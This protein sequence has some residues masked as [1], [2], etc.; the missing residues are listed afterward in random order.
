M[1][2]SDHD[3]LAVDLVLDVPIFASAY[4]RFNLE[5]LHEKEFKDLFYRAWEGW[6][7]LRGMANSPI[8]WWEGIKGKFRR[9]AQGYCSR[10]K[11]RREREVLG[12]QGQLEGLYR[13]YNRGEGFDR[14]EAVRLKGQLREK[15]ESRA[16]EFLFRAQGDELEKGEWCSAYF[17]GKVREARRKKVIRGLRGDDGSV[18]TD[19][20]GMG[21]VAA[22]FYRSLFEEREVDWEKGETFLGRLR[23]RLGEE[24]RN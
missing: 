14:E 12:L 22:R 10:R 20:R 7:T 8:E 6:L 24:D 1:W 16:R 23:R 17:F 19:V 5:I 13:K 2:F 18:V 21:R 11:S 15:F 4:W 9:L 3:G